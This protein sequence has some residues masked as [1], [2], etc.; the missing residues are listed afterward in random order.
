LTKPE[1]E[2]GVRDIWE[3]AESVSYNLHPPLLRRFGLRKKVRFG[4]WFRKTLLGLKSLRKLRG[5]PL[6]VF[7]YSAHRRQERALIQWYRDLIEQ[8]IH[9]LRPDNLPLALEI[10]ALPDQIRGY[11]AIK[12]QSIANVKKLAVEKLKAMRASMAVA[13]A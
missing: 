11:E 8:V 10:A 4:P 7:G 3:S 13:S 9:N 12:E 5:T 6:D 2:R 1:F